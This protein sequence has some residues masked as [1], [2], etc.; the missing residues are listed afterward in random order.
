MDNYKINTQ[1]GFTPTAVLPRCDNPR[2]G[3]TSSSLNAGA[4][5]EDRHG[6]LLRR[7]PLFKIYQSKRNYSKQKM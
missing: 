1:G 2:T 7:L 5:W 6:P 3:V 4:V